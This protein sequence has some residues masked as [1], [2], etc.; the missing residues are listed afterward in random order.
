[1]N[2]ATTIQTPSEIIQE[3]SR[4][5]DRAELSHNPWDFVEARRL[6]NNDLVQAI[7]RSTFSPHTRGGLGRAAVEHKQQPKG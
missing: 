3:I 4:L 1:M 6:L 7:N 2:C 5:I